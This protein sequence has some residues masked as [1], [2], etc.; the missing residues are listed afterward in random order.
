MRLLLS[1]LLCGVLAWSGQASASLRPAPCPMSQAGAQVQM[2]AMDA[3]ADAFNEDCC[4]DEATVATTGQ[5]CKAQLAC[6]V[7]AALPT[8]L[9]GLPEPVPGS[10][11]PVAAAAQ[12]WLSWAPAGLWRPPT[13]I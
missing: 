9:A 7:A 10:V 12:D 6:A 5:H 8:S 2:A 1:L 3:A 11:P 13:L 4:N